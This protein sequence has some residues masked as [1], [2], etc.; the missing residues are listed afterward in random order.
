MEEE[1]KIGNPNKYTIKLRALQVCVKS[2]YAVMGCVRAAMIITG[3]EIQEIPEEI[4]KKVRR[5][6]YEFAFRLD[7]IYIAWR[8][9]CYYSLILTHAQC[10]FGGL[11]IMT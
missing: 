6:Q 8:F 7:Y 2:P 9:S 11:Q 5:T 3:S 1:Y 10:Q 4:T